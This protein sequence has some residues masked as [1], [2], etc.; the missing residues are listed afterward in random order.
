MAVGDRAE[1]RF[2]EHGVAVLPRVGSRVTD[3]L[4][5]ELARCGRDVLD[6]HAHPQRELPAHV[7]EAVVAAARD[8]RTMPSRGLPALRQAIA[9]RL[10]AELGAPI[11]PEREVLVTAGAM[12]ALDLVFRATAVEA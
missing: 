6:L 3:E 5:A 4:A 2:V 7:V 9:D 8:N 1:R 12:Q 10:G 11:D